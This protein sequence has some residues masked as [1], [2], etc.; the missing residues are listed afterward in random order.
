M[1]FSFRTVAWI[2]P[3]IFEKK[4]YTEKCDVYSYG[5]I[6]W[7]LFSR[8]IPYADVSSFEIPVKVAKEGLR[9]KI[10]DNVPKSISK[11]MKQCWHAKPTKRP[12]FKATVKIVLKLWDAW[13]PSNNSL[14]PGPSILS[15]VSDLST[16]RSS[17]DLGKF[18]EFR[19]K[20][21]VKKSKED[22]N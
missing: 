2:A 11:L 1:T 12:S 14:S 9:P 6:F 10:P 8:K 20:R 4:Q 17:I 16:R 18:M 15:K 19:L 5:I 21:S 22:A 13:S 7:E 3:E